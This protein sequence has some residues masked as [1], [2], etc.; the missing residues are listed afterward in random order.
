MTR[1]QDGYV[2][3]QRLI[4]RLF[5]H[6]PKEIIMSSIQ[7]KSNPNQAAEKSAPSNGKL[8]G[9]KDLQGKGLQRSPVEP[10]H[11]NA[12]SDKD[13]SKDGKKV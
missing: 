8:V 6:L 7:T 4:P 13:S 3:L 2:C 10:A 11:K 5:Q 9:N 12:D 1:Y